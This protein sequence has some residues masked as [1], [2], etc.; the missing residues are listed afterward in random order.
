ME[1]FKNFKSNK[2]ENMNQIKGGGLPWWLSG[3]L[4]DAAKFLVLEGNYTYGKRMY[5]NGSP[6]GHK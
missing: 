6:G 2:V 5:E 1:H 4:Y 3:V